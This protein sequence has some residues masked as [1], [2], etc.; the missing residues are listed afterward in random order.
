MGFWAT[1]YGYLAVAAV[2][3]ATLARLHKG[4]IFNEAV[5]AAHL[6]WFAWLFTNAVLD[7][8]NVRGSI[9]NFPYVDAFT[10]GIFGVLMTKRFRWWKLFLWVLLIFQVYWWFRFAYDYR[11]TPRTYVIV[12][13]ISFGIEVC[14]VKLGIFASYARKYLVLR[15]KMRLVSA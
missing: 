15:Q 9:A 4:R 13:N 8:K 7:L 1:F 6:L 3:V 2:A 14:I 5:I 10:A 12:Q 11:I